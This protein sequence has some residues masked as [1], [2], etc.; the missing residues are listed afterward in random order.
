M[1]KAL[2]I[3][4]PVYDFALYDLF[5]KPYGLMRLARCFSNSGY[6]VDFLNCLDYRDAGSAEHFGLPK[7]KKNG[8]GKFF[9]QIIALPPGLSGASRT[10]AR[11]GILPELIEERIAASMADVVLMSTMMTYWYQGLSEVAAVCRR[12]FPDVPVIAGGPYATLMPDHCLERCGIDEVVI[13]GE[14]S[15]LERLL[16]R[17]GLPVPQF[18]RAGIPEEVLLDTG[19]WRDAGVLRL[20]KGCPMSCEYCASQLLCGGFSPGDPDDAFR[21]LLE[22]NRTCSTVNFAFYDDA[23][24]VQKDTVFKPFLRR[25]I[26]HYKKGGVR[27]NFYCPNALHIRYLD[28][29]C[30][31][32]MVQ[33]GF[34][35]VRLGFESSRAD[36]HAEYDQKLDVDYLPE[37]ARLLR[38]A[39]FSEGNI[40]V[41]ILAGMPGQYAAEVEE[42]IRY[43]ANAGLQVSLAEYSPVP[44]SSLWRKSIELSRLA[45]EK[46]PLFH[47]NSF[48]PMEWDGFKRED[49]HRLKVLTRRLNAQRR[50]SDTF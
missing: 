35:E 16:A 7:R 21:R 8:T 26:E 17:R 22:M 3:Q 24:L 38:A 30:A 42:S 10:Y 33:A 31:E 39:G 49:L 6:E 32:L 15:S 34:R 18:P 44:G 14:F 2:C 4:P 45:L 47:N 40:R 29:E 36:F 50:A 23:L 19:L 37:S 12:L 20:N 5:L 41:Y 28:G 9:R 27:F 43:A 13:G 46:E 11:Y 48:F 25:I 1:P